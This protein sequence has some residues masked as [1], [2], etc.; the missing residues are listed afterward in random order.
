LA[1]FAWPPQIS[2]TFFP[3]MLTQSEAPTSSP[4]VSFSWRRSRTR[5]NAGSQGP[6]TMAMAK[7]V[8]FLVLGGWR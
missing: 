3:L 8:W 6:C 2:R 1:A 7:T 4:E 5:L